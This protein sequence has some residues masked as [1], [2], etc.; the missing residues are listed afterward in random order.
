MLLIPSLCLL[1]II[2]SK[3]TKPFVL[4]ELNNEHLAQLMIVV[5]T[6]ILEFHRKYP[7]SIL[8]HSLQ[9]EDRIIDC[10]DRNDA[11]GLLRELNHT[12]LSSLFLEHHGELNFEGTTGYLRAY[13]WHIV[14]D[15]KLL[16]KVR[17]CNRMG[18][19]VPEEETELFEAL[20]DAID[21][22]LEEHSLV[23]TVE[24]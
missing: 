19:N 6:L 13:C 4:D 8:T 22:Y 20:A 23:E 2:M 11:Q 10:V 9:S 3:F 12:D 21:K 16:K 14:R 15:D 24:E 1:K 7:K 17:F 18:N 5:F